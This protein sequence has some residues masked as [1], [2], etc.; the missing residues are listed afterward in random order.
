MRNNQNRIPENNSGGALGI[1][2]G[3]WLN[4]F[5]SIVLFCGIVAILAV[6]VVT[7]YEHVIG[8]S[9]VSMEFTGDGGII[10]HS[11][12]NPRSGSILVPASSGW[13][14]TGFRLKPGDEV[15]IQA[16]G[17]IHLAVSHLVEAANEDIK[18]KFDWVDPS[19]NKY[20][21]APD[22]LR[23]DLLVDPNQRIGKLLGYLAEPELEEKSRPGADN[24]RPGKILP[25]G[26]NEV[27]HNTEGFERELWLVVNDMYLNE[28]AENAYVGNVTG[29]IKQARLEAWK[30]IKQDKYWQLWFEDNIGEF[31]VNII[32]E[33]RK[34]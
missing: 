21:S 2:V 3:S 4:V 25:I 16:S 29:K 7:S 9:E 30:R 5:R 17:K 14:N 26:K 27:I 6:S 31:L 8:N 28:D 1:L 33:N 34:K 12:N 13:L 11:K 18:L 19:G 22:D 20:V 23:K 24:P 10:F 32:Y 15:R